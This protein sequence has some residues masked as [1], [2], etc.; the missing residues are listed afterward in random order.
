MH[1]PPP[2]GFRPAEGVLW[3]REDGHPPAFLTRERR[4]TGRRGQGVR[5]ERKVHDYLAEKAGDIYRRGPWFCFGGEEYTRWCQPDG[6]ILDEAAGL[7]TIVEVKY[8]H[9]ADA[10]WQLRELYLP[11][12]SL[13]YGPDWRIAMLEVVRW[14]DPHTSFPETPLLTPDPLSPPHGRIGVHIWA[15]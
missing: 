6:L 7:L 5:Y 11:V 13:A 2:K 4:Y 3:A 14:Y 9:T 12:V 8:Q 1:C 15:G 10:W